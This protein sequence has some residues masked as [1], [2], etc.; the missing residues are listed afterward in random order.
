MRELCS[1]WECDVKRD[2]LHQY[3][4]YKCEGLITM[5]INSDSEA[6]FSSTFYL[7]FANY[8]IGVLLVVKQPLLTPLILWNILDGRSIFEIIHLRK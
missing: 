1:L 3:S 2:L 8:L 7:H 5:K 6:I 4:T